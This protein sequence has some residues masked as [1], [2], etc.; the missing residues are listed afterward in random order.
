[1]LIDFS[2][3]SPNQRYFAMTQTIVPR[4]VAW[5]LSDNGNASFNLAPF[6]YFNA[7]CSAPPLLMISIGKKPSGERKDTVVNVLERQHFVLHIPHWEMAE[8]VTETSRTLDHGCSEL[9]NVS[10]SLTDFAGFPLPRISQCRVAYGCVLHQVYEMGDVPQTLLVGEVKQLYLDDDVA[11]FNEKGQ[12]QVEAMSLDP[13]SR[14]GGSE[15]GR[16]G[17]IKNVPRPK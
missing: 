11:Q 1:M 6:S 16:L 15:Y 17:E 13:L 9:D 3:L 14:L 12:L 8:A 5:V 4:P 2:A 7:V 10:V